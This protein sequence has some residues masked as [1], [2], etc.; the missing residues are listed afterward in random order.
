MQH[1]LCYL[2]LFVFFLCDLSR[3]AHSPHWPEPSAGSR[4]REPHPLG[5]AAQPD[6]AD[7]SYLGH[8]TNLV[9]GDLPDVVSCLFVVVSVV[10]VVVIFVVVSYCCCV[11]FF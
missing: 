11:V 2:L 5:S 6:C 10:V 8:D 7:L 1:F 4:H 9:S 3:I